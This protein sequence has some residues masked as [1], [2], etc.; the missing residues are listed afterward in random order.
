MEKRERVITESH[1]TVCACVSMC[2]REGWS[3]DVRERIKDGKVGGTEA[4]DVSPIPCR[5]PFHQRP[6]DHQGM[7]LSRP[8][9]FSAWR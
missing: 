1:T 3:R 4:E 6:A 9:V 7:P 8:L 5:R 2:V